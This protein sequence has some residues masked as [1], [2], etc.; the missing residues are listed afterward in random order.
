V[1]K[2]PAVLIMA[3][4]AANSD[5]EN[6]LLLTSSTSSGLF[7]IWGWWRGGWSLGRGWQKSRTYDIL[8]CLILK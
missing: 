5:N 7:R 6:S 3:L 2:H 4:F 8:G 1:A